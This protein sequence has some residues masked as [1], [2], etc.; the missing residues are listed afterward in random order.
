MAK[1]LY[2]FQADLKHLENLQRLLKE[3]NKELKSMQS[4]TTTSK[5]AI[6]KQATS[7]K[8]LNTQLDATKNKARQVT[9]AT[10]QV[11]GAG[12]SMVNVFKS[13][14]VAI[15]AAFAVRAISGGIRGMLNTFKEFEARM[16]AVKAISGA[17]EKEFGKLEE[18]ALQ[19]GRTTVF[20]ASQIAKLQE[21]FARLGFL[22]EQIIEMQEATV[23]LAA[24]TGE[25]LG[26]A[27]A[28]A[29]S[30]LNAF[31]YE[32][33]QTSRIIDVMAASFTGS[34][35]NLE[36]FTESMK[37]V[38]PIARSVGFTIE[39]TTA[40][41]MKL[42]DAGLHGSIAG[43]ALK[44]ILLQL[45]DSNS[46]LTKHL[47]GPVRGLDDLIG[48]LETL[49]GEA[50]GAT[51]AAELLN[52]R[53]TPAFL[54]LVGNTEGLK[55]LS[56][57][58]TFV[59]GAAREMAA[60]RLNTLEGDIILMQSAME[61]LG[62]AMG[63]TFDITLRKTVTS[64]TD[65]LQSFAESEGALNIFRKTLSFLVG[66]L[67]A[68]LIKI[69][70]VRAITI[71]WTALI[72]LKNI[73]IM[74]TSTVMTIYRGGVLLATGQI[75]AM[76]AATGIATV[77]TNTFRAALAATP[78]GLI[79]FAVGGLVMAFSDLGEEM[80]EIEFQTDRIISGYEKVHKQTEGLI[81]GDKELIR[82]RKELKEGFPEILE[83][84]D[85]EI[86]KME[87]LEDIKRVFKIN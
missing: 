1:T 27:A 17:T 19:L 46:K 64:F 43:N 72:W 35:L 67:G 79:A 8:K 69:I 58:L 11:T 49:K 13:A 26:N 54:T 7:T 82:I 38:A 39:E 40:L 34:A 36:R 84:I 50:F 15:A 30:V 12:R 71:G 57:S 76:S 66:G 74:A 85:V 75:T 32:A 63:E 52:K 61:G 80:D 31:G 68:L 25:D 44:N 21:E 18:T 41:L 29:G 78:W 62:I 20:S 81:D 16:A 59:D 65:F 2:T 56:E 10:N 5:K 9:T 28:T 14:A 47:G 45:G 53:A 77:A 22:P 73:A 60:I 23:L 4:S 83:S 42:S 55:E 33:S 87:E 51:Q 24:A 37:F 48:R 3:A 6:D 86:A 70:A